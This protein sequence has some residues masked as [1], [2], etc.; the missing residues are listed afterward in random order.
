MSPL[1]YLETSLHKHNDSNSLYAIS[2]NAAA[3]PEEVPER[4]EEWLRRC[5]RGIIFSAM[6]VETQEGSSNLSE[7][8]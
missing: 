7:E 8:S 1:T 6:N 2:I 3:T 5:M 4:E